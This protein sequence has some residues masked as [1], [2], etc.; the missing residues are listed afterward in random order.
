MSHLSSV[1]SE[2]L[3][4]SAVGMHCVIPD[5]NSAQWPGK[6]RWA[7]ARTRSR[8][9]STSRN[10]S[11]YG[12]TVSAS[13][14]P[15]AE[16]L[17]S[18]SGVADEIPATNGKE[19]PV[20]S[21]DGAMHPACQR[22][23]WDRGGI[24]NPRATVASCN[25]PRVSAP[26]LARSTR[27]QYSSHQRCIGGD[28]PRAMKSSNAGSLPNKKGRIMLSPRWATTAE[29]AEV[30]KDI[31]RFGE[32]GAERNAQ[33]HRPEASAQTPSAD[34][35]Y[36][37]IVGAGEHSAKG[38]REPGQPSAFASAYSPRQRSYRHGKRHR[39][40]TQWV[41]ARKVSAGCRARRVGYD[42]NVAAL[43][44]IAAFPAAAK[45]TTRCGTPPADRRRGAGGQKCRGWTRAARRNVEPS[46]ISI[47]FGMFIT[48][49]VGSSCPEAAEKHGVNPSHF[50]QF[51]RSID[52]VFR[53]L[54]LESG[55]PRFQPAA[56]REPFVDTTRGTSHLTSYMTI[57]FS[58]FRDWTPILREFL[59]A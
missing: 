35:V 31:D 14:L 20:L 42:C 24:R 37:Q 22:P 3:V 11:R 27:V 30:A 39:L 2:T 45:A 17:S 9:S 34:R 10:R 58:R 40:R 36:Q 44:Y 55:V 29:A 41:C 47:R 8:S 48:S 32:P 54:R 52:I 4:H 50:R 12:P 33:C 56:L 57:R 1:K 28:M 21:Y 51:T 18:A 19:H 13:S 46:R 6:L 26:M 7:V 59:G 23:D 53:L 38:P 5:H 43:G 49:L 16:T 25:P 15:S